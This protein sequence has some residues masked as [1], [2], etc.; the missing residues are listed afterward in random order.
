MV[1][2]IWIDT[3]ALV[4]NEFLSHFKNRFEKPQEARLKLNMDFPCNLTLVQQADLETEVTKEDIKRAVWDCGVDKSPGPDGFTFSF[5]RHYW[6]L[7]ENDVVD[8]VKY[9]FQYG[10][11]LKVVIPLLLL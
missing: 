7:I 8:A 10:F 4:K 2:G 11:I 9:F 1:I 3:P 5:Y 6:K